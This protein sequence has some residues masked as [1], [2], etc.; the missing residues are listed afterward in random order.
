[1]LDDGVFGHTRR[2]VQ[3]DAAG[4]TQLECA[5][6]AAVRGHDFV[7]DVA[8]FVLRLGGSSLLRH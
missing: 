1:M 7:T 5:L 3:R 2:L 8:Q 6:V 4:Q